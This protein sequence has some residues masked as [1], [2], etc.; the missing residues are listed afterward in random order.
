MKVQKIEIITRMSLV[1]AT[2]N[3]AMF[4]SAADLYAK[5]TEGRC[6]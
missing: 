3:N 2:M 1:G 5:V 4:P 6:V